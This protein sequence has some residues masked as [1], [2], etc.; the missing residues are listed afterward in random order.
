MYTRGFGEGLIN[1]IKGLC[2]GRGACNWKRKRASRQAIEVSINEIER[3]EGAWGLII[4]AR[5]GAYIRG[6]T[7]GFMFLLTGRKASNCYK[8]ISLWGGLIS[9]SLQYV[10]TMPVLTGFI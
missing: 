7:I 6:V 3:R 1:E 5:G 2:S 9:G 10:P 4:G 8:F